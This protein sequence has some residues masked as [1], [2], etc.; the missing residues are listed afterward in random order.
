M[1][2]GQ[3]DKHV[4]RWIR[5][6]H[7][8]WEKESNCIHTEDVFLSQPPFSGSC[9]FEFLFDQKSYER[10]KGEKVRRRCVAPQRLAYSPRPLDPNSQFEGVDLYF[11]EVNSLWW[12]KYTSNGKQS[13]FVQ[14]NMNQN[15][16]NHHSLNLLCNTVSRNLKTAVKFLLIPANVNNLKIEYILLLAPQ[17]IQY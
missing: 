8:S 14:S 16:I 1:P 6:Q 10:G 4:M 15:I 5:S 3:E 7:S 17:V 9:W 2:S 11:S 12:Y 13:F